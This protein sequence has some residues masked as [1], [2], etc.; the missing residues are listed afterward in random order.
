MYHDGEENADAI[1]IDGEQLQQGVYS[2]SDCPSTT[3][4]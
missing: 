3:V 1:A 4:G 2:G